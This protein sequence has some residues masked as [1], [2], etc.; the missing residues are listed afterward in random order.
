[1]LYEER[2]TCAYIIHLPCCL[3]GSAL[4]TL[5]LCLRCISLRMPVIIKRRIK[6]HV[7]VK[8]MVCLKPKGSVSDARESWGTHLQNSARFSEVPYEST[9][10]RKKNI[11]SNS[12]TGDTNTS[13]YPA[14]AS[15]A[16]VH[17]FTLE[18]DHNLETNNKLELKVKV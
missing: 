16:D 5:P 3:D 8:N 1:M 18:W 7:I 17:C 10:C 9:A 2:S 11:F 13:N 14:A 15:S 4:N 12:A 6:S